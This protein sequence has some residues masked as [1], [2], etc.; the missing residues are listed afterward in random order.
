M[1]TVR[2]FV[3]QIAAGLQALH[4][5][6]ML[7]QDLRPQNVMIDSAGTLRIIDFGS[8]RVAG[9]AED[10]SPLPQGELLGTV[11]YMAPE[12]LLGEAADSRADL[13]SLGVIA[14][15]MLSGRLP[16]GADVAR[17]RTRT[18]QR[19][20]RYRSVLADDREIPAWIDEVLR[21]AVQP[22]PNRRYAELSEFVH[23]LR[24]PNADYLRRARVPLLER[25]PVAFWRGLALLLALALALTWLSRWR[26]G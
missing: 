10:I 25:N 24:H 18:A 26:G 8:T 13:Y 9:I 1:E 23:D 4:R 12:Y 22:D 19:R 21:K 5:L 15:Q 3:E 11:Q 16:F 6:E 20:L 2:G 17:A 14:Y 7:H